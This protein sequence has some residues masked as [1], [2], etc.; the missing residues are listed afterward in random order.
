MHQDPSWHVRRFTSNHIAKDDALIEIGKVHEL[1]RVE[2]KFAKILTQH[3]RAEVV[4][5]VGFPQ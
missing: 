4:S 5:E 1:I 3:W 2:K